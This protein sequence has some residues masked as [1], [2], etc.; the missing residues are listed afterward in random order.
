LF[1]VYLSEVCDVLATAMAEL[2]NLLPP[3]EV[4]EALLRL[5]YGPEIICHIVANQPDSFRDGKFTSCQTPRT[6]PKEPS[7]LFLNTLDHKLPKFYELQL[8][9]LNVYFT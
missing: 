4:A 5:K 1:Q 6:I 7:L 8:K 3:A 9:L 2:P